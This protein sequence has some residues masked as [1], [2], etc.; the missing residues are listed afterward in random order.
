M[1]DVAVIVNLHINE[2][3][4]TVHGPL[5][6]RFNGFNENFEYNDMSEAKK[7]A[8]IFIDIFNSI[9]EDEDKDKMKKLGSFIKTFK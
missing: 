2:N 8:M 3:N 1:R 7:T 4:L 6:R 9:M 5:I